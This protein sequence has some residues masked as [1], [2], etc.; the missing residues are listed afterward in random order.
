MLRWGVIDRFKMFPAA[1][2]SQV[3]PLR[4]GG[5]PA[6]VAH[7]DWS[8]PAPVVIWFHG[9]TANK[10]LDPGR[11]LRWIRAG[12]AACAVDLP[13]HGE[14]FDETMQKPERSLD[15]IETGVREVDGIVASL[16]ELSERESWPIDLDR[17]G[18]GGMSAGGM[19]TLRRLC[20][21]HQ[22][23]CVAV[24]ATTGDLGG[25]YFAE[26]G[27]RWPVTHS[28]ERVSRVDPSEHLDGWRPIPLLAL[29]SE[30][31]RI[32]PVAGQRAF[33]ERLRRQYSERGMDPA[34]VEWLTWPETG[35]PEE[36]IG[37]GRVSND[38]KNAQTA[39]FRKWLIDAA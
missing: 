17:M 18:I 36:H 35:A 22:F 9:R 12:I 38:A 30:A 1:L 29:H 3:R 25:L 31:D 26:S 21:P 33:I 5:A 37:F 2:A 32:I 13:G 7:P 15:V 39:F 23:R 34:M 8:R 16:R 6:L 10:E 24:E 19:V 4:L 27:P 28:R 20:E 14:R 11:Y